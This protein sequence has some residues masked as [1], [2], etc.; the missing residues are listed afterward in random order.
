VSP[1]FLLLGHV[2]P[3]LG[4]MV[5]VIVVV[6]WQIRTVQPYHLITNQPVLLVSNA[7]ME[8]VCQL[9]P[10][11]LPLG[12]V[13]PIGLTKQ[14]IWCSFLSLHRLVIVDVVEMTLI[15]RSRQILYQIVRVR[16]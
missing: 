13:I 6:G 2:L 7:S 12:F 8:L 5:F 16:E 15:V 1:T 14:E 4:A 11:L 10:S 9:L 3:K